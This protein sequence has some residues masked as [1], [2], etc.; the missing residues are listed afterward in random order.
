MRLKLLAVL[1]LGAAG[2]LGGCLPGR[3]A[4]S[5][6]SDTTL[7]GGSYTFTSVNVPAGV[8]VTLK[9]NVVMNV[10]G[11]VTVA[12]KIA[13]DCT[14]LEVRAGGGLELSGQLD[15]SCASP[16]GAPPGIKLVVAGPVTVGAPGSSTP[17]IRSAGDIFISD[18]ATENT[19][20]EPLPR[21][22]QGARPA[23]AGGGITVNAPEQAGPGGSVS[24][25][26]EGPVTVNADLTAGNGADG[27]AMN[28]AGTC[29][30][31]TP[32]RNGGSVRLGSRQ[33]TLTIG[34]NVTLRAGDG[35]KGG[36]CT[37]PSGCPASATAAKGGDGGSVLVG[38]QTINFG[39]GVT[40]RRGSGGAGGDAT[41]TADAGANP[42][43]KGCDATATAGKGGNTGGVGYIVLQ[44]GT[45]NGAP[46]EAGAN[47]GEG[48]LAT[49][50]GGNGRD[51]DQ[52]PA[53]KGGDGGAATARGGDGGDGAAGNIW[54]IAPASHLK[55]D[56]GDATATG[57]NGGKGANCCKFLEGGD[58][59][60]GGLAT[61]NAG[62]P[63]TKGMGGGGNPGT[64]GGKGGD[65]GNGGDGS[66][67]GSKGPKGAGVGTPND[68][69]DGADGKDGNACALEIWFIYY[70]SIADGAIAPGTDLV[71]K[72]YGQKSE[73]DPAPGTETGSVN[74]HFQ[75]AQEFGA[76]VQYAKS[77]DDVIV[78]A[79]GIVHD[80][81]ALP[82]TFPVASVE[83]QVYNRCNTPG[84]VKLIGTYQGEPVATVDNQATSEIETLKLPP[85]PA[86]VPEYDGFVL[87]GSF[88]FNHWWILIID[89][90]PRAP[91]AAKAVGLPHSL[92]LPQPRLPGLS[93]S[94]SL[95][96]RSPKAFSSVP[97]VVS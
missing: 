66:P 61:A 1:A 70:S 5:P 24:H 91:H 42:C 14:G 29:A 93:F 25:F 94:S 9:G 12:G 4:F 87:R 77:A 85:P 44:P 18:P 60:N 74:V 92:P 20:L 32:G 21:S 11:N 67:P 39:A 7:G 84:C 53:G 57:G 76:D 58:G 6:G 64:A 3:Q 2:W 13:G 86:G 45:I 54:P 43:A 23:Q 15:T 34:N 46:I 47:G 88:Q 37:A 33:N 35:G 41:A 97:T 31:T 55:G 69:P 26:S 63:G 8:T 48:G 79:G 90:W 95:P 82:P 81:S 89:P 78:F 50:T 36:S 96:S 56:G 16:P 52:C 10:S 28:V 30:N 49:A 59:G 19:P 75:T 73:S 27:G 71:L 40:V 83:A 17:A 62:L 38:G 65:G 80:L 68:I 22:L 51:C 72:T